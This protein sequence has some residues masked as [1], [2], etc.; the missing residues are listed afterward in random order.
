MIKD[1]DIWPTVISHLNQVQLGHKLFPGP[2]ELTKE[3][4]SVS[5]QVICA[6]CSSQREYPKLV[7]IP[8]DSGSD[9]KHPQSLHSLASYLQLQHG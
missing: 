3:L 9:E 1:G 4:A 6:R 5:K 2:A 7:L 8:P